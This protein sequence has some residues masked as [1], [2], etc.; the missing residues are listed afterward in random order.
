MD[1]MDGWRAM[2]VGWTE[3]QAAAGV[4]W[5]WFLAGLAGAMGAVLG[6]WRSDGGLVANVSTQPG[7]DRGQ[8]ASQAASC[9]H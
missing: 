5:G 6:C 7:Q 4:F 8:P 2:E 1:W 9:R 3:E